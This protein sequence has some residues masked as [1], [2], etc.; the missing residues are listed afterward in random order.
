MRNMENEKA[1]AL[2]SQMFLTCFSEE[3]KEALTL[4]IEKLTADT[5]MPFVVCPKCGQ[6]YRRKVANHVKDEFDVELY[7][8]YCPK[9][10]A[11]YEWQECYWR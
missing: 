11:K 7:A 8:S 3:E 2:L 1:I 6:R 5:T 4:A 10:G 9:C